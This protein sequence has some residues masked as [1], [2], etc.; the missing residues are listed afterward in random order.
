MDAERSFLGSDV[1]PAVLRERDASAFGL[2]PSRLA[3]KLE[4]ELVNLREARGGDGMAT[5]LETSRRVDRL[6]A[7]HGGLAGEGRLATLA[8][9]GLSQFSE[10]SFVNFVQTC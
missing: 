4:Y 2:T 9:V 1:S 5:A 7:A 3:A 8:L 10:D 6:S